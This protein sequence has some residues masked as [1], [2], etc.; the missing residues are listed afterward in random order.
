MYPSESG[1]A[2]GRTVRAIIFIC[3]NKYAMLRKNSERLQNKLSGVLITLEKG[4]SPST[5]CTVLIFAKIS[6]D[7]L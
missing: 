7:Y 3:V 1:K 5:F 2:R 4:P 6:M